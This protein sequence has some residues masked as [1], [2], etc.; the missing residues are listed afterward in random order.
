MNNEPEEIEPED[1]A[2]AMAWP[3]IPAAEIVKGNTLTSTRLI[4]IGC[5]YG[6]PTS[7]R[8]A[9]RLLKLRDELM[10]KSVRDG[11]PISVRISKG[12]LHINTD[13][14]ASIYHHDRGENGIHMVKR[15]V[16]ALA[17]IVDASRL[18]SAEQQSHDRK[19]CIW[20][21]RMA[22]LKRSTKNFEQEKIK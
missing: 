18:S 19:L 4:E 14:E 13:A 12:G 6:D 3:G 20:G 5:I 8:Y 15:Q 1:L 9:F 17:N 21:A 7:G 22:A 2:E 16:S 10:Q 11:T